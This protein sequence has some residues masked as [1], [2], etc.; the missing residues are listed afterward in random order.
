MED[1]NSNRKT[2]EFNEAA[3]QIQRLHDIWVDIENALTKGNLITWKF[4]L[5]SVRR[6]LIADIEY[7]MEDKESILKKD[8]IL[9]VNIARSRTKQQLYDNLNKRHEFMKILQDKAGKGGKYYDSSEEDF[10]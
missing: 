3:Y 6:E 8:E 10:E 7:R 5:D 4:K 1:D 9:K 2:S